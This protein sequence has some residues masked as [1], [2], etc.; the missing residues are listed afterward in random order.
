MI[1]FHPDDNLLTEYASGSL[2]WALALSMKTHLSM[3]PQCRTRVDELITLGAV[4]LDTQNVAHAQLDEPQI[5]DSER[6]AKLMNKIKA[7][8]AEQSQKAPIDNTEQTPSNRSEKRPS[9]SAL[10]GLPPIVQT[11]IKSE[12]TLNWKRLSP[13]LKQARL[14]TGQ[15]KYEV[16]LHKIRKGGKVAE[17]DHGG[18]EI[19]VILHGAFSDENGSYSKGDFLRREPGDKH[20]PTASQDQ[21]C[22]CLSIVE[23]PVVITGIMGRV[24][25]P[26]LKFNPA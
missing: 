23:A 8:S 2:D 13:S 26:F 12:K 4:L 21:D 20:R 15:D 25:N 14:A 18:T 1:H 6:F 22:I 5:K 9:N 16:S 7:K 24:I 11:L 3:C 10:E 19:T 17:H